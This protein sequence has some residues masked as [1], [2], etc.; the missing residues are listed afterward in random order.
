MPN[1]TPEN[2]QFEIGKAVVLKEGKD[3]SIFATGH[4]V[5]PALEAAYML[6]D[7]G[8]AA[9]VINIHTI[10]PLDNKAVLDSVM[11]TKCV[12]TAEEHLLNGGLGDS[13]AQLLVRN[14]PV[15]QEYVAM[16][17][18]FGIS[19]NRK[20]CCRILAWTKNIYLTQV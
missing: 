1:F 18:R 6:H 7:K 16:E 2:Q 13:V 14:Y 5:Y 17:D 15:P 10:K 4:L 20:K 3:I 12:V 8:I 19:G 9:E 11:K